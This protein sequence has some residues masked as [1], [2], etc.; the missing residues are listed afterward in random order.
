MGRQAT[1]LFEQAER[2]GGLR[3][4][5]ALAVHTRVP[6]TEAA[7]GP[8][9]PELL[10]RLEAGLATVRQQFARGIPARG[11]ETGRHAVPQPAS[12]G[13]SAEAALRRYQ[14]TYLELMSQRALL[15]GDLD[16]TVRRVT[17]AASHA[18]DVE[19]VSIWRVDPAVSKITCADLFQ[20]AESAHSSGLELF[21]R[22]YQPYFDALHRQRTIAAHD[23]HTDPRTSC[24]SAG[25]LTPLGIGA[26][27]DVPIWLGDAMVGVVCHE[28]VGGVRTWTEDEETF[29]YLMASFCSLAMEMQR[30]SRTPPRG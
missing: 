7:S 12:P 19:R 8:D 24:F 28:H 23:A 9:T 6:S 25:Y 11:E 1:L 22:D 18:L 16:T 26:M 17:E 4:K 20:R 27:L 15:L 10:A 21:A 13:R 29:A 3:A 2:I 30:V 5:I 14:Q